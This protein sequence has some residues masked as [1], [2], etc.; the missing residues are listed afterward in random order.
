M[1]NKCHHSKAI[2]EAHICISAVW[3]FSAWHKLVHPRGG[4][5]TGTMPLPDWPAGKPAECF[6]Y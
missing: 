1:K 4:D 3:M 6:L 2:D 5:L